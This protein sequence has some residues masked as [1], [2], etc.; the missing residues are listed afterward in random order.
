M[1]YIM[2]FCAL[3]WRFFIEV[4]CRDVYEEIVYS[5]YKELKDFPSKDK[6]IMNICREDGTIKVNKSKF[7]DFITYTFDFKDFGINSGEIGFSI[8]FCD[9]NGAVDFEQVI[10]KV[11]TGYESFLFEIDDG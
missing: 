4:L 3:E 8:V 11:G 9:D 7:T 1:K 6:Y 10:S 2:R 5:D